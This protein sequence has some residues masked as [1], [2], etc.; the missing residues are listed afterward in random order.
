MVTVGLISH[1][2][3]RDGLSV[4]E[5]GRYIRIENLK[6]LNKKYFIFKK[7][8]VETINF[9]KNFFSYVSR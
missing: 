5:H 4:K 1:W 6:I 9:K 3:E 8:C 7:K 2:A